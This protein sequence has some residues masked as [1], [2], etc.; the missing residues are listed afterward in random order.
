MRIAVDAWAPDFGPATPAST[1]QQPTTGPVD[2]NVEVAADDWAPTTPA[3][4]ACA[5]TD[6]RFVDGVRRIDARVWA[7]DG[8]DGEPPRT[9]PALA[10]SYGAGT[11]R[12]NGRAEVETCEVR[13]ELVGPAGLP[14]LATGTIHYQPVAVPAEDDDGLVAAVQQRM[15]QLEIAVAG[16]VDPAELTVVDGPLSGRQNVPGAVG[17]V[18]THRAAYLPPVAQGIVAALE[19]GQRTPLF[20]TQTS[21][22][23]YSWYLRLPHGTG[24]PWA[25]VVRLEAAAD[26]PV[27]EVVRLADCTALTLPRFAS[28]PYRDPRAPQNLLPIAGLERALKRRLGDAGL[29]ERHLRVAASRL[30]EVTA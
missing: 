1:D 6:V 26:L 30:G 8:G 17:Y 3:A 28:Q 29:L 20:L 15:G 10:V 4:S 24:H 16:R 13:H 25:G 11:V 12:C 5:A 27:P 9:R 22:S 7:T 21:W 18:K 14:P 2:L 23:R 19:A